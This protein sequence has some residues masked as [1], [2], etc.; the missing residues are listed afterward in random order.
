MFQYSLIELTE[1]ADMR[2]DEASVNLGS[3]FSEHL[4]SFD[5]FRRATCYELLNILNGHIDYAFEVPG[6]EAFW[7][8]VVARRTL[9]VR[10]QPY[11]SCH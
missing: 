11:F 1:M 5:L 8:A 3:A 4:Q 9:T 2:R 6:L 10:G 7:N